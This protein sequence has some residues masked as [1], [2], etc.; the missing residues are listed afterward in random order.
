MYII[1]L[2]NPHFLSEV[3]LLMFDFHP[4]LWIKYQAH[5]YSKTHFQK[6]LIYYN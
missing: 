1:L 4:C 5:C 2:I 6:L 3:V